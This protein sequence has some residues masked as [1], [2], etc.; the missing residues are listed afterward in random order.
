MQTALAMCT[1]LSTTLT[2]V[3]NGV[4]RS[5]FVGSVQLLSA[6]VHK[7]RDQVRLYCASTPA[8]QQ[9]PTCIQRGDYQVHLRLESLHTCMLLALVDPDALMPTAPPGLACKRFCDSTSAHGAP[10]L[11]SAAALCAPCRLQLAR[12]GCS[13]WAKCWQQ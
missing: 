7:H 9:S 6:L 12:A 3:P 13:V 5:K 2:R 1:V 10:C 11:T 4:L 8:W